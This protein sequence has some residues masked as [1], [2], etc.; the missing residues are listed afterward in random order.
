M[1]RITFAL[2]TMLSTTSISLPAG[3]SDAPRIIGMAKA[4]DGDNLNIG[5]I[6]IRLHGIDAP[7]AGQ[8]C[9][10]SDGRS[11]QCGTEAANRLAELAE[12]LEVECIALDRDPSRRIVARCVAGG[13]DINATMIEEGMAWAFVRY[14]NDYTAQEGRARSAGLGI[15]QGDAEPAW[16]YRANRWQRAADVAPRAGCPIKGNI[17]SEGERIFHTP[18]SPV[19]DRVKIDTEAEE[20]WF[21]DEDEAERAGWRAARWR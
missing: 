7:E 14:S 4:T 13:V 15:W 6:V 5:P 18:W 20:R 8:T 3:A 11:W 16:E 21:C 2:A 9:K 17:N 19:Y 12:K 10:R 1:S